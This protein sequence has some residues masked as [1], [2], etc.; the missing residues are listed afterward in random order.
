MITTG[1]GG[2]GCA[3]YDCGRPEDY[4]V[5][6]LNTVLRIARHGRSLG[7]THIVLS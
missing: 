2:Q 7:A 4:L 3:I 5:D 1:P 6:R